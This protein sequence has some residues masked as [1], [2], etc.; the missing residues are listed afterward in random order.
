M[1]SL[2]GGKA[3]GADV[4]IA[5]AIAKLL[6][7]KAQINTTGFDVLI[8]ALLAKKCDAIISAMTD[9][10]A[11]AKTVDFSDYVTVGMLLMVKN[12]NPSHI[13]DL[14]SLSGK[15]VAVEAATTEKDTLVAEN[16]VLAKSVSK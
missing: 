16:K 9:T 6:G 5:D 2:V 11:R 13:T 12:G 3:A 4:D 14:A 7:E 1:E 10:P 8:P 15:T